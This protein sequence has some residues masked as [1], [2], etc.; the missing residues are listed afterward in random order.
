MLAIQTKFAFF[1]NSVTCFR[2]ECFRGLLSLHNETLFH[3]YT[4]SRKHASVSPAQTTQVYKLIKSISY[5]KYY[6]YMD[7]ETGDLSLSS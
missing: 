4:G 1:K 5:C 3:L 2:S 7:V 6:D